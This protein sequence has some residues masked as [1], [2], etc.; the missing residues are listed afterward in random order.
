MDDIYSYFSGDK[1]TSLWK[2]RVT[3][4][5]GKSITVKTVS[6]GWNLVL[7]A[8][9]IGFSDD[10]YHVFPDP[11]ST[12]AKFQDVIV[13]GKTGKQRSFAYISGGNMP[14]FFLV[15]Q[16]IWERIESLTSMDLNMEISRSSILASMD[17]NLKDLFRYVMMHD[18]DCLTVSWDAIGEPST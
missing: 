7:K 14:N 15:G 9:Q 6:S 11:W 17:K 16:K 4:L 5:E 8:N 10:Q 13:S 3:L 1:M 12:K 2:H 18:F